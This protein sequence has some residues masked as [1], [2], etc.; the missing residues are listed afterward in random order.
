MELVDESEFRYLQ[1]T[2]QDVEDL[3]QAT[4]PLENLTT[5]SGAVAAANTW[6]LTPGSLK[7]QLELWTKLG[8]YQLVWSASKDFQV[9]AG[10]EMTGTFLDAVNDVITSLRNHGTPVRAQIFEGNKTIVILEG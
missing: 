10:V 4:V 3:R 9:D 1:G 2:G 5:D 6:R 8:G 7:N